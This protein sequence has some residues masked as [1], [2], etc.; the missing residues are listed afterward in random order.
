MRLLVVAPDALHIRGLKKRTATVVSLLFFSLNASAGEIN[1]AT[2]ASFLSALSTAQPGDVIRLMPGTYGFDD[3]IRLNRTF[4]PATPVTITAVGEVGSVVFNVNNSEGFYVAGAGWVVE[5]VWVR[6]VAGATCEGAA[7]FSIKETAR[8]VT[9]RNCRTTDWYQHFKASILTDGTGGGAEDVTIQNCESFNTA[10]YGGKTNVINLDGGK[11]WR[12]IGNYVHDF[13]SGSVNYGIYFKGGITDSL[14]EKNLVIC[15]KDRPS[16]GAAVGMSFGGGRM[17]VQFCAADNKGTGGCRC[18]DTGGIARNNVIMHCND[19]GFHINSACG[20]RIFNNLI[21][22]TSPGLQLQSMQA[23]VDPIVFK[24][25]VVTGSV[26]NASSQLVASA[27]LINSNAGAVQAFYRGLEAIDLAAG[28]NAQG[29][30]GAAVLAEVTD[31]Y[32]GSARTG[33]P[34]MG[35]IEFPARCE[36][37]PWP[38]SATGGVDAGTGTLVDSG[39]PVTDAGTAVGSVDSGVAAVDSGVAAI[40]ADGGS[41][42]EDVVKGQCGCEANPS[43]MVA[44]VLVLVLVLRRRAPRASIL[45]SN[46]SSVD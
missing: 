3:K 38:S 8:H 19:S 45:C 28:S 33:A 44:G 10:S 12:V 14:M 9:I 46:A 6:C 27:N 39:V 18:E 11:R 37:W 41:I 42:G 24:N 13:A 21:Y 4:D 22:D 30:S 35:P 29:P 17:A 25:N 26:P 23:G 7:G 32:C 43:V 20:S 16:A 5:K 1:V 31:D 40:G 34:F 15:S 36:T 2:S